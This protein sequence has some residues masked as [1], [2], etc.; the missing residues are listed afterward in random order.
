MVNGPTLS[1]PPYSN[2]GYKHPDEAESTTNRFEYPIIV[3]MV[4][5][6]STVLD[7]GC[8]DGSLG[9]LL[10]TKGC[11]VFGLEIDPNG[12]AQSQRKGVDAKICDIESGL[13]YPDNSFD[14]A[15]I[16]VTLQML[17]RPLYVLEEA[18][19]VSQKQVVSFPNFAHLPA[20]IEM[21]IYGRMP[22]TALFGYEWYNTRHIHHITYNDF[23]S[24]IKKLGLKILKV[25]T[26]D[27]RGRKEDWLSRFFPS[28][29]CGTAIFLL[30]K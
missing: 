16:N 29:F 25:K 5:E 23:V 3:S 22:K 21:L 8:G 6:G 10:I 19:R 9:K 24:T 28:L 27:L 30:E 15:I 18:V 12:V 4:K 20:R 26:L 13:P 14:Y 11:K 1:I 17:Y 7:I 2:Y